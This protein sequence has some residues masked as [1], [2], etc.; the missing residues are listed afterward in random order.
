M[1]SGSAVHHLIKHTESCLSD[2]QSFVMGMKYIVVVDTV[3]DIVATASTWNGATLPPRQT[4]ES[5][6]ETAS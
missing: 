3:A 4:I 2:V 5:I 6:Q 1:P